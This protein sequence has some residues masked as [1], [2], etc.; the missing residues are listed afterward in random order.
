MRIT[1]H[2]S[3]RRPIATH[4]ADTTPD[5]AM[6]YALARLREFASAAAYATI[7]DDG[8]PAAPGIM[9]RNPHA[10]TGSDNQ[11]QP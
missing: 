10:S 1:F 6:Q 11:R 4:R 7:E 9:V 2:D 3:Q 5:A 8:D